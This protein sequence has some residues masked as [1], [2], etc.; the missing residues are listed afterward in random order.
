MTT[1]LHMDASVRGERSLTRRLTRDF[2]EHFLAEAPG[3]RVLRR[4]LA[5]TP[6]PFV[7]QDWIT[8]S[9]TDPADRTPD[10][11]RSLAASD[12]LLN[13]LEVADLLVLG[14]PMYNYGMPARLKAWVDQVIRVGRTFTFDLARG[15]YPLKPVLAGKKLVLLTSSG[16]F[17][18][19]PGEERSGMNHFDT[20]LAVL[21]G[22]LGIAERYHVAVEYQEFGD[23]RHAASV[24]EATR[25]VPL[26]ARLAASFSPPRSGDADHKRP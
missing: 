18:F 26:L 20:H 4:D 25:A 5:A 9:F 23:N 21:E 6:P 7:D 19:G 22:Y 14:T 8:S 3:T 24:A 17:G 2:V 16:E 13:E 15:D 12:E 11:V 1:L 10:M